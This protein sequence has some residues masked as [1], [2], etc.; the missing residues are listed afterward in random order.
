MDICNFL[1]V[2]M[3]QRHKL[4]ILLSRKVAKDADMY[5]NNHFVMLHD[6]LRELSICQSKEKPFEQRE[7]LIIDLNG[8]NRPEWWIGQDE[9]GV[10][11]RMSSFFLRMLYR[12]KQLRVAAR[13][14]SI[15]TGM[16][17]FVQILGSAHTQ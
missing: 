3:K 4:F 16:F 1:L 6:L 11:G 14:L 5:Y 9:Q 12:Q 2:I 15:S 8:D 7:R 13:I 10:I 17:L